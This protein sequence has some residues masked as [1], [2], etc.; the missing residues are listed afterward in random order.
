MLQVVQH[1]K[2]GV[3][4]VLEVPS[5]VLTH[6]RVLVQTVASL[7]S[8][9]T[10]R[11]TVETAQASMAKKVRLRPDLVQQVLANVRREGVVKTY[12]KVQNRLDRYKEL[13]Y[14]A[15]G[16][17]LESDVEDYRK[18]DRVAC[19]GAGYAVHA[20][21]ISV[22]KNLLATVPTSVSLEDASFTTL[23][24]IALQGVRQADVRLGETVVVIGLGLIGLLSVQLLRAAGCRVVGLD[25]A[26]DQF[27][28]A[29]QLGCQLVRVSSTSSVQDVL[30]FT[31]GIGAD[32]V[33]VTAA[34]RTNEPLEL[35]QNL[36]RRKGRIVLV[37]VSTIAFS[38]SPF[39]EKELEFRISTSYGPGRYDPS[40]EEEGQ[41]YPI[42]Y[43]RWTERRNMDAFLDLLGQK[44]IS[45]QELT[46]HRFPIQ[47]AIQAYDLITGKKKERYSG[48][49][50]TYPT[51]DIAREHRIE[52]DSSQHRSIEGSQ[53]TLAVIG[54]GNFVQSQLLP[55]IPR[56]TVTRKWV[57]T[58]HPVTARS[59]ATK[60]RFEQAGTDPEE[61]FDDSDVTAVLIGTR[62]DSHGDL[63]ARALRHGK[64]VFVEKPLALT[65]EEL[66]DIESAFLE[67]P[68]SRRPILMVGYNRRF[69]QPFADMR[70]FFSSRQE[71]L[72]MLYRVN[73]GVLPR[74]HW[75]QH[76]SQ[77]GRIIGELCHFIDAM[78]WFTGSQLLSVC[79]GAIA[80][81]NSSLVAE[82]TTTVL[83]KFL[84][85]SIGT[86]GYFGNGSSRLEKE[87]FEIH[88]GGRSCVMDD[89]RRVRFYMDGRVR[90]QRY[91]G[92][93][94]HRQ[95]MES[96]FE[97]VGGGRPSPM[98][99]QAVVEA[100]RA[101]FAVRES[102][103]S[104]VPVTLDEAKRR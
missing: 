101:T 36:T 26:R 90:E 37:G 66:S 95:E 99:F 63:T 55:H 39:Y 19:A 52:V 103:R 22:P 7:I 51:R 93:K 16:I 83:L 9:G 21:V 11:T 58:A 96:F 53:A 12:S 84:D 13:G 62:H 2:T 46:T 27:D 104:G 75:T 100:T 31:H 57:V 43:V 15:A 45:V 6:G 54:A 69:S 60:Y 3:L 67:S 40:Y 64:H 59:T 42:G 48:I 41:D 10:E 61:V 80:T 14:S 77:G 44:R 47:D 79:A 86:I 30:S 29:L 56:T 72:A 92:T 94:G 18:G 89:F 28:L 49:I 34:A 4:E 17:V 50:L 24:A 74:A 33:I 68:E 91:D 32:A 97:A 85:G 35:A 5:P 20:E 8:A 76:P 82:D 38:R 71:P 23:G 81:H 1:Q 25:I 78:C 88:G 87:Y 98:A 102:I 73:A 70:Q 65:P